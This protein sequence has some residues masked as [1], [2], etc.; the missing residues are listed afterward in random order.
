MTT[1]TK[2][3]RA[4]IIL[5]CAHAIAE[6]YGTTAEKLLSPAAYR[7]QNIQNA[8]SV[9]AYHLHDCGISIAT[10]AKLLTRSIYSTEERTRKGVIFLM[11]SDR[12]MI[13]SLPR[14]PLT[15]NVSRA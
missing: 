9:F 15:L 11:G 3:E 4:K 10:I 8:R 14:I 13:E 5:Q 7:G 12:K 6:F 2:K 1:E